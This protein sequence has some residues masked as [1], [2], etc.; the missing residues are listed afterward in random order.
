[1]SNELQFVRVTEPALF[2]R[3][4]PKL[5]QQVKNM[6]LDIEMLYRL[7]PGYIT[8]PLSLIYLMVDMEN[9][10]QGILW[11]GLN[12]TSPNLHVH[13]CSVDPEYQNN[14]V[15]EMVNK[16]L[17]EIHTELGLSGKITA[18]TSRP[19]AMAKQGWTQTRTVMMELNHG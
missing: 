18:Y 11:C 2:N 13:I 5:F 8:S 14:G 1:M 19:K 4:P 16:K 9:H 3:I 10:P 17:H 15:G 6:D 7:L 12:P